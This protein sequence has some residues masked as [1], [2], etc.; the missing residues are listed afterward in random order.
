MRFLELRN[1]LQ[2]QHGWNHR[3][4]TIAARLY[5]YIDTADSLTAAQSG[6]YGRPLLTETEYKQIVGAW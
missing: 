6:D 5:L 1:L 2:E 4:A 3:V